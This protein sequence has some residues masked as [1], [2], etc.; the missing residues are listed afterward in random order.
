M[1]EKRV[2]DKEGIEREFRAGMKSLRE[3][4]DEF[5]VSHV[6]VSKLAREKGWERDLSAK[7]R[8]KAEALVSK[9]AVTS[10]VNVGSKLDERAV[11]EANA[12]VQASIRR[13]HR[14]DIQRT[15]RIVNKLLEKLEG[16]PTKEDTLKEQA[17]VVKQLADTQR[18]VVAM[19]R[20]AFGIAQMVEA[21]PEAPVTAVNELDAVRRMAFA[22]ARAGHQANQPPKEPT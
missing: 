18:V 12:Q 13:E 7:I 19:E 9:E 3:I 10:L 15:K 11:I 17:S 1:S 5:A 6:Y 20:E 14:T 16:L 21:P 4:G 8:A 2:I 22:L